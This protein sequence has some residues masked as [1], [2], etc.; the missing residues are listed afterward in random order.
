M[1]F[2]A[3]LHAMHT[4]HAFVCLGV[5]DKKYVFVEAYVFLLLFPI[6][7][8][9]DAQP[10]N[11]SVPTCS[12]GKTTIFESSQKVSMLMEMSRTPSASAN[13]SSVN[14]G[15]EKG[16]KWRRKTTMMMALARMPRALMMWLKY[17]LTNSSSKWCGNQ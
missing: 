14:M 10:E 2:Y 1:L 7:A 16:R 15:A 8:R 3:C 6:Y 12:N 17:P 13:A 11:C 4:L 5:D 9:V